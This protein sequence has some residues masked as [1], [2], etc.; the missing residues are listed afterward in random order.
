MMARKQRSHGPRRHSGVVHGEQ[1][2]LGDTLTIGAEGS[3]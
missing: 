1:L 3:V 2:M